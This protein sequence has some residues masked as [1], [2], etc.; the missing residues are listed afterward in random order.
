[1]DLIIIAFIAYWSMSIT[2]TSKTEDKYFKGNFKLTYK[3][4]SEEESELN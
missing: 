3:K 1:M 4:L 2:Y